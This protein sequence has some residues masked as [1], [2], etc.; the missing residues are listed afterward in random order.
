M[1]PQ[2]FNSL[3][4][5]TVIVELKNDVIFKG[6]IQ[7]CD[8][9]TNI[10]LVELTFLNKKDFPQVPTITSALIRGSS[11]RYIHLP[12]DEVNLEQLH[13]LTLAH[14]E[15]FAQQVKANSQRKPQRKQNSF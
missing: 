1:F 6:K 5:H 2:F 13:N 7:S 8:E 4:G 11:V 12:P 15:E 9:R 14:A 3:R 10:K